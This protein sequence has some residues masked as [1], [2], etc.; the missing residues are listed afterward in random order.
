MMS[1]YL[2]CLFLFL[3]FSSAFGIEVKIP[4]LTRVELY[5]KY[6]KNKIKTKI[7]GKPITL[8][9]YASKE[10]ESFKLY[11]DE[12]FKSLYFNGKK[13]CDFKL[14]KQG[15]T[16]RRVSHVCKEKN[17]G[18]NIAHILRKGSLYPTMEGV[19]DVI[20]VVGEK[21]DPKGQMIIRMP[22]KNVKFKKILFDNYGLGMEVHRKRA[23]RLIEKDPSLV[24]FINDLKDCLEKFDIKDE[25]SE[26]YIIWPNRQGN[27]LSFLYMKSRGRSKTLQRRGDKKLHDYIKSGKRSDLALEKSSFSNGLLN[28][29]RKAASNP[30]EYIRHRAN[31]NIHLTA[32]PVEYGIS[33]KKIDGEWTVLGYSIL[34]WG[35]N[36]HEMKQYFILHPEEE[37]LQNL[38]W[39]Y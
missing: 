34:Y 28:V 7:D 11:L 26:K 5:L 3:A 15:S 27:P 30:S 13:I 35:G 21:G 2:L 16:E 39:S 20:D 10:D 8:L 24:K 29:V 4:E 37:E 18:L 14:F 38:Y 22:T 19:F 31:G 23:K 36:I 12:E 9:E 17:K 32:N 1:K 6:K 33:I 25:C